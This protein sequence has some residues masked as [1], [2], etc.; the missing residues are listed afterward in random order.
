M[1][2]IL[3]GAAL[4]VLVACADTSN[5]PT[6]Q[7]TGP[8]LSQNAKSEIARPLKGSCDRDVTVISIGPDGSL[9]LSIN[10][11]CHLS[12]L[13]LSHNSVI[14]TITP[15][16]PPVNGL[17]PGIAHNTGAYV[18]ANGDRIN[19][20]FT[21]TGVLD[22]AHFSSVF[23]GTETFSGGTGRF[24]NASGSAHVEGTGTT[25]PTTGKGTS[26]ITLDGTITY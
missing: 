9:E 1:R 10:Y 15:T 22:L 19:S 18:A 25:D 3:R 2:P 11:T 23:E 6:D 24:A 12:H 20:S 16:G 4:A 13:G 21:A 7:V 17:L 5:L 26:H 8:S 14:E